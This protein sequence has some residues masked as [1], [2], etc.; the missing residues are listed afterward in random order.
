[1][2]SYDFIIIVVVDSYTAWIPLIQPSPKYGPTI[3]SLVFQDFSFL[4]HGIASRA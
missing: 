4:V 3:S 2:I 1:L